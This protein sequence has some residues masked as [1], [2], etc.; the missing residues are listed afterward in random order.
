M[1]WPYW[2]SLVTSIFQ[3]VSLQARRTFWPRLPIATDRYS[4]GTITSMDRLV[5]S[6]TTREIS[7]GAKALQTNFAVSLC[8]GMISIF[9]PFSSCTTLWTRLPFMPTHAPTGSM[10]ESLDATAIFARLPGSRAAA[11]MFTM[12]S[13]IS[14][15]SPL[16]RAIR[17]CGWVRDNMI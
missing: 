13:L 6:I 16:N 2:V 15:T 14:G 8:Q 12:P 9:S 5:S 17:N 10:S 7:A 4:S 3:P 1:A 11:M